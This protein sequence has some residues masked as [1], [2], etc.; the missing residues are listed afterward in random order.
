VT[1]AREPN[2]TP[3]A[4]K[5][6]IDLLGEKGA[7]DAV[8]LKPRIVRLWSEPDNR[9]CP[10]FEQARLLDAAW[11]ASGGDG[12]PLLES[13][14]FHLNIV[15]AAEEACRRKL[16]DAIAAMP[17]E[18][19]EAVAA[20]IDALAPGSTPRTFSRALTETLQAHGA[21]TRLLNRLA[22]FAPPACATVR[23][24][25]PPPMGG[26]APMPRPQR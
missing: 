4:V 25:V 22:A 15:V 2:S 19:G 24:L 1:K 7:A 26:S 20:T 8:G 12:A 16:F 3:W 5:Q 18:C 6:I 23:R 10:S 21:V 9:R 11:H 17:R 14:T 13:Y